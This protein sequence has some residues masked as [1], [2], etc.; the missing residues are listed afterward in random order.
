M[1]YKEFMS[2]ESAGL[3]KAAIAQPFDRAP[4]CFSVRV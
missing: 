3:K 1:N 4:E 2:A